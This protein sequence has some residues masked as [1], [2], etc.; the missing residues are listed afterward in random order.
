M[1]EVS[2]KGL[3]TLS[4]LLKGLNY[5]RS[6][7]FQKNEGKGI[8]KEN[9]KAVVSKTVLSALASKASKVKR[10]TINKSSHPFSRYASESN[11]LMSQKNRGLRSE[12]EDLANTKLRPNYE[13]FSEYP[14]FR[15]F[16]SFRLNTYIVTLV[17]KMHYRSVRY[18]TD[19]LTIKVH[20]FEL[21]LDSQ[22]I[23]KDRNLIERFYQAPRSSEQSLEM[24]ILSSL[25]QLKKD[26]FG[27]VFRSSSRNEKRQKTEAIEMKDLKRVFWQSNVQREIRSS[28]DVIH[29]DFLKLDDY[30]GKLTVSCD[31]YYTFRNFD[32]YVYFEFTSHARR[33]II[34]KLLLNK[35]DI[36]NHISKDIAINLFDK[37]WMCKKMQEFLSLV[38]FERSK[39]YSKPKV[40]YSKSNVSPARIYENK[41]KC[42]LEKLSYMEKRSDNRVVIGQFV[43]NFGGRYGVV[44]VLRNSDLKEYNIEVYFPKTQKRFI[45]GIFDEELINLDKGLITEIFEVNAYEILYIIEDQNFNYQ[46]V[47]ETV[48]K[49][50]VD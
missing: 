25:I 42:S 20:C 43:R 36:E 13:D 24:F 26:P 7:E 37:V 6:K 38:I 18:N 28:F 23:I 39:A 35:V 11:R 16:I 47:L 17:M 31:V 40:R 8:V 41:F 27:C 14:P 48:D 15:N 34:S 10:S 30:H 44:S 21:N 45:F 4:V 29:F 19:L 22:I 33:N 49:L 12:N 5:E 3:P 32:C 2:I 46:K 9:R 50:K 1:S